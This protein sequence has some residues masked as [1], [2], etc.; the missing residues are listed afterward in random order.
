MNAAAPA[1]ARGGIPRQPYDS[2]T[3]SASTVS[4]LGT[5]SSLVVF[6]VGSDWASVSVDGELTNAHTNTSC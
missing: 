2:E 3:W 4:Q 1:A 5:S 6:E